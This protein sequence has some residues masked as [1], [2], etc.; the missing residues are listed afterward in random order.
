MKKYLILALF[1]FSPFL[2]ADTPLPSDQA[3]D[4][5]ATAKDN[6][7]ILVQWQIAPKYYLY[8]NKFAFDVYRPEHLT[9]ASPLFPAGDQL[10]KTQLGSFD[11]YANHVLI[12]L[13]LLQSTQD[14]IVLEAH[15]QGCSQNGY[16]YPPTQKLIPINLA[17]NY[18]QWKKPLKIDIVKTDPPLTNAVISESLFHH[19]IFWMALIF[20]GF[21]ILIAFTPCVLP[22]IP[23]L[24]SMI[25]GQKQKHHTIRPAQSF[26][27]SLFYVLGMAITYAVAGVLFAYLGSNIQASLQQPWVIIV[28]SALFL[29]LALSLFGL[30][31][32]QL[33]YR[34]RNKLANV[35]HQSGSYLSAGVM[36]CLSTLILSPCVTPPLVA[37]LGFV[38]QTGNLVLGGIL[39][40]IMGIGMGTPLLLIGLLGPRVLPKSG[41]WMNTIKIVLGLM[42][43]AVTI[44][45]L[46]RI[47]D[48]T[49]AMILWGLLLIGA[50]LY[51]ISRSISF[52]RLMGNTAGLLLL[53]YGV[54]VLYGTY[55][56]FDNPFNLFQRQIAAKE[57]LPFHVIYSLS[58][59][60]ELIQKYP[61]KPVM[62]D[63]YASWCIDCR[64]L[65]AFVFTKPEVKA[66][67]KGYLLIRADI[68]KTNPEIEALMKHFKVIAPPTIL[69]LK[70]GKEV[71][72]RITGITSTE[73][74]LKHV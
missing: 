55:H 74:F 26:L 30:F 6:Q 9:L 44:L 62:M 19:N 52:K 73:G 53:I 14:H 40:F 28:F 38:S 20:L 8:K 27:L 7:T 32:I 63:F 57:S 12:T 58:E 54:L 65:D 47:I 41:A 33:P 36:G 4:V 1:F 15:Y 39:L 35:Q 25:V 56:R 2:F 71:G 45:M 60:Q 24:S 18:M 61:G 13:P 43:L 42:M 48:S 34:L 22:M 31:E 16:C 59:Y 67:L 21:G 3:F 17:S 49:S 37:V 72:S 50:G 29:L 11:V 64:A 10:L 5:R 23:I 51:F 68:T 69:F 46:Q 66:A 70:D